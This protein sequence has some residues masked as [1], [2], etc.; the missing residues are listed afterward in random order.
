MPQPF[1]VFNKYKR[2]EKEKNLGVLDH[3]LAAARPVQDRVVVLG[4]RLEHLGGKAGLSL[5]MNG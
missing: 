2:R 4:Q 1:G 3:A 5:S